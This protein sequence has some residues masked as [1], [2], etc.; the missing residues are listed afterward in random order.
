M[1]RIDTALKSGTE[2]LVNVAQKSQLRREENL[3]AVAYVQ[4]NCDNPSGREGFVRE[5]MKHVSVDSYGG[6]LKNKEFPKGSD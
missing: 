6:C 1:S 3:S 4:S 5:L 2:Y